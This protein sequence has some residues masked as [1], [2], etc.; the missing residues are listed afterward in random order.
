[1]AAVYVF[2][3]YLFRSLFI[4]CCAVIFCFGKVFGEAFIASEGICNGV[5]EQHHVRVVFNPRSDN[6][7]HF[8]VNENVVGVVFCHFIQCV[9]VSIG[10]INPKL[11]RGM[12]FGF[13]IYDTIN[14]SRK[15]ILAECFACSSICLGLV[16]IFTEWYLWQL[17]Q[18]MRCL[19]PYLLPR[20]L[21]L[22]EL[23]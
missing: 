1:M 4:L 17:L 5:C 7:V 13:Y 21:V 11:E 3:S 23:Q 19:V 8:F 2:V 6:G 16:F 12:Y 20:S 9:L 15:S 22:L 18:D 10:A 14:M